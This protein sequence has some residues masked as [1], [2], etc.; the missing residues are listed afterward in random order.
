MVKLQLLSPDAV[1]VLGIRCNSASLG[2]ATM[3]W[4]SLLPCDNLVCS[5]VR[6]GSVPWW[7]K[8]KGPGTYSGTQ[9]LIVASD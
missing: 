8:G 1:T 2:I 6:H 4:F 5:C 9:S 7:P 3:S